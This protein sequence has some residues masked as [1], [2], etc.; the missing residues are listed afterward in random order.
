[1]AER[2]SSALPGAVRDAG[3]RPGGRPD[4][5]PA[6][7]RHA[8][9]SGPPGGTVVRLWLVDL[10]ADAAVENL[11]GS[12]LAEGE[13]WRVHRGTT[14]VRRRRVLLRAALRE[15]AGRLLGVAPPDVP[16]VE[17]AGRPVLADGGRDL[18]IS[19]SAGGRVGLVAIT[20]DTP[21]GV[22]VEPH[23]EEDFASVLDEG[24]LAPAEADRLVT[25]PP[26]LR[27]EAITRCWTQ[28]EA[29][30]KGLGLGLHRHPATVRTPRD[31]AGRIDEWAVDA[32]PVPAGHAASVAVR[33]ERTGIELVIEDLA[34]EG[35][36]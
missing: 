33:T 23:R 2:A 27:V 8:R 7:R 12:H 18:G 31:A 32:V 21:V 3:E 5:G 25:L 35:L 36:R 28:K 19:C 16:L 24:W 26:A 30:L 13:R 14:A 34:L 6:G 1:M 29:V 9:T 22:D 20:E 4:D 11:A 15:A 17:V 10:R